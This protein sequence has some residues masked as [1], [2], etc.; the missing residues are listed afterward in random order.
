M[1]NVE[2]G[3]VVSQTDDSYGNAITTIGNWSTA[4]LVNPNPKKWAEIVQHISNTHKE[5]T[6]EKWDILFSYLQTLA[7]TDCSSFLY[8]IKIV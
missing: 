5:L 3:N 7:N 2:T 8:M 4:S 1:C 6:N